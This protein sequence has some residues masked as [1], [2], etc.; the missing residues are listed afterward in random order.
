MC[1]RLVGLT[2]LC[3]LGLIITY[4]C[5]LRSDYLLGQKSIETSQHPSSNKRIHCYHLALL[6]DIVD[7]S[8]LCSI[9]SLARAF[10]SPESN[11][12][13]IWT[14]DVE[15]FEKDHDVILKD[16]RSILLGN[17]NEL[18]VDKVDF[19]EIIQGTPLE[20]LYTGL[21]PLGKFEKQNRANAIRLAIIYKEG[22]MYLD[23][24]MITVRD[25]GLL[26]NGAGWEL[27]RIRDKR[28]PLLNNAAFRFERKSPMLLQLMT[29][30]VR[31]YN[32]DKWGMNGPS[33]FTRT[34]KDF[35]TLQRDEHPMYY[36]C[37]N[38][39]TF[40]VWPPR[41]IYPIGMPKIKS[42]YS[43]DLGYLL[44]VSDPIFIH[45]W[46]HASK[47][48]EES[49]CKKGSTPY[50]NSILGVARFSL[51]PTSFKVWALDRNCKYEELFEQ[52][53]VAFRKALRPID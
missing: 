26:E 17:K 18:I 3:L 9:E 12:I 34:F 7:T 13:H 49:T 2:I 30:F 43:Q 39:E 40:Q 10:R 16:V 50:I 5:F 1:M 35:C 53:R 14:T 51:C 46:S 48:T 28:Y 44:K 33:L 29:Q 42:N 38:N 45:F 36:K 41:L 11:I 37:D 31:H 47:S 25:P 23:G 8:T 19:N 21:K 32:G 22:G 4:Q 20:L 27:Y 52:K 6:Y 15:R 24:D